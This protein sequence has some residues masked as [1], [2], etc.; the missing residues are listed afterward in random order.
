MEE[1]YAKLLAGYCLDIQ[2][3]DR[4]Y[5][6]TTF[7]AQPLVHHFYRE[8]LQRG[9]H[10]NVDFSFPEQ[11]KL[12]IE[13]VTTDDQL[14]WCS[15]QQ[16]A[17]IHD[18]DAYLVIRAPY[19]LREDHG[20]DGDRLKARAAH[21][22][23]LNEAYFRRTA[24]GEL[25]RCLCQYP[26]Q[27]AAQEAGMSLSAY[28]DF[29]FG[30]CG[31]LDPNPEEYWLRVRKEQQHIVDHLNKVSSMRYLNKTTDI[32]FEVKDRIWINSD[33]RS[34]MPS[35]EVFTAPIEDSVNGTVHFT[36]PAIY[37]GA[38]VED[39]VLTVKD[40]LIVE[41]DA[42]VGKTVL[43]EVF[44]IEG[45]KRF[46]E[47]AIGTNYHI[48]KVTKNILFDEKIGG[49]IHMAV[50]QS[51]LQNGGKNQSTIHWD[52]ITDMQDGGQIYADGQLIYEDGKFLI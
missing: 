44:A 18:Y 1:S 46:G 19:N 32:C 21:L 6:R 38:S 50:G 43:D 35:G 45:A 47:V 20:L 49:S 24:A 27:A 15:P 11:Q 23:P 5:V 10:V 34:N 12:F 7:L 2:K 25:K 52:M 13:H 14:A 51:Y 9:A 33:G 36:Y 28:R 26:T 22:K 40:G 4:V 16:H 48:Q 39:I 8:A 42:K 37:R 3:G 41:W 29:V 17:G 31:L 30:A